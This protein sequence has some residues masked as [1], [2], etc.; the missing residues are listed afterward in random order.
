MK[1]FG[2]LLLFTRATRQQLW[3]FTFQRYVNKQ[4]ISLRTVCLIM[5]ESL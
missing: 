5:H 2:L 3:E 4:N 1:F